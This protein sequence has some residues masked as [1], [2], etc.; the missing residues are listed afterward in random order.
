MGTFSYGSKRVRFS[1]LNMYVDP[2]D[3][4]HDLTYYEQE[5]DSQCIPWAVFLTRTG[6]RFQF[7]LVAEGWH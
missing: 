7:A 5:L 3:N 6:D 4:L 1:K 2:V